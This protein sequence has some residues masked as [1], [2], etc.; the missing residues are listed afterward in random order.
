MRPDIRNL[1]ALA[2]RGRDL[3]DKALRRTFGALP[4]PRAAQLLPIRNAPT[5][6]R[7]VVRLYGAI[8]LSY[9]DD[10]SVSAGDL[11]R[12]L[13]T[14]GPNGIDLHINSGG[15]DVFDG[16]AMHGLLLD[17]PSDVEVM[18]DGIAA[19][20]AS[21]VAMAGGK[22]RV[23]KP[24]KMMIHNARGVGWGVDK[25]EAHELGDLLEEMDTTIAQMYADRS[26]TDAAEW[27]AYMDAETWFSAARAVEV[28]LA[29]EVANDRAA[30]RTPDEEDVPAEEDQPAED[31]KAKG[32]APEDRRTA[33]I[34]A[35]AR[36]ALALK[37]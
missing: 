33:T 37:G 34:R 26:G 7:T 35:R 1:V 32:D 22:V 4:R 23:Q 12:T 16:I 27:T 13:D 17:H 6:G 10:E 24:A 18:V 29:D 3:R 15:G 11:A 30:A 25:H 21:F 2:D 31:S 19:S 28:G 14:I 36:L 20:A 5:T 9:W 8:G